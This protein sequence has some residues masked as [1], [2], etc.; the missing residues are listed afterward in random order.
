VTVDFTKDKEVGSFQPSIVS[1]ETMSNPCSLFSC[2][3][4]LRR[5]VTKELKLSKKVSSRGIYK[6]SRTPHI[7]V[8]PGSRYRVINASRCATWV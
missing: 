2:L 4:K 5:H 8:R 3:G 6:R 1:F 7:G